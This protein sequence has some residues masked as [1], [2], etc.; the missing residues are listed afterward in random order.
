MRN[1]YTP[2]T[3]EQIA[4]AHATANAILTVFLDAVHNSSEAATEL[5]NIMLTEAFESIDGPLV[6][7]IMGMRAIAAIR[8]AADQQQVDPMEMWQQ[9]CLNI[10]GDRG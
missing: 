10:A 4:Q 6:M 2:P 8:Y 7:Q 3:A 5:G 1:R 9:I